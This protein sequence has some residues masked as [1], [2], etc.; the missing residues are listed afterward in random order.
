MVLAR[1]TP[2]YYNGHVDLMRRLEGN[3]GYRQEGA[4]R[5]SVLSLGYIG[6]L[7]LETGGSAKG[8]G[9]RFSCTIITWMSARTGAD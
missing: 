2:G 1:I 4:Y 6:R 5:Q 8:R 7:G 9:H 3:I